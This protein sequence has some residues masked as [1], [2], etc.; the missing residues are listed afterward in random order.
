MIGTKTA[1]TSVNPSQEFCITWT[2]RLFVLP[3]ENRVQ[4]RNIITWSE[5]IAA[6]LSSSR[7]PLI[8]DATSSAL[9]SVDITWPKACSL[10]SCMFCGYSRLHKGH[11][12]CG[13]LLPSEFTPK[14][15]TRPDIDGVSEQINQ[16]SRNT[17]HFSL[18]S[19]NDI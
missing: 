12:S 5:T 6:I 18:F 15:G 17:I 1:M 9:V 14:T 3:F 19:N 2:L 11:K 16:I 4:L 10:A 13:S 7:K 8:K